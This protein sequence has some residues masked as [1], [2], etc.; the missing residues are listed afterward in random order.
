MGILLNPGNAEFKMSFNSDIYVDKSELIIQTNSILNKENRFVCISRPRRFGKSMAANMLTAYYSCGCD[1]KVFFD[2]LKIS[3]ADDYTEP[4]NKYNVIHLNMTQYVSVTGTI[5]SEIEKLSKR[6][7]FELHKENPDVEC[8]DPESLVD[9][10]ADIFAQKN[11][12]FIFIIDE[13]D[14]IFRMHKD[15]KDAQ[16]Y[17]LNF[18]RNL[19]K[20]RSY[21]ALA[22]MTGILPIKKYG[23]HSALNMFTEISIAGADNYAEF[24]GFTEEEVKKL[25]NKY[26]MPYDEIKQWYDGYN[27]DNISIYN[28]KSVVEAMLRHRIDNFWSK[29]ET[30]KALADYIQA[31]YDDLHNKVVRLIGG[32]K[33]E[34]DVTT[35]QNDMVTFNSS[36]DIL[37]LLIHLGYLTYD[38]DTK[39]CW[40]PN[41]E[42]QEEFIRSIKNDKGWSKIM[43]AIK[44]SDEL[45]QAVLD[46]NADIVAAGVE[47]CHDDNT[48]ILKFNDENSLSCV[49][50][51]AFYSARKYYMIVREMPAGKGFADLV[52]LPLPKVDKPALV[53]ELKNKQAV[54]T[55]IDQIKKKNYPDRIKEYIGNV[56]LVGITYNDDKHH[57]CVI[58]KI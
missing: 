17:Y 10:L 1:S 21:V 45:L 25:C 58:E 38:F 11:I 39:R 28:P 43:S 49:I 26:Q 42:V 8:F 50:S 3:K 47:K 24:T 5:E 27:V 2:K 9:V 52:F 41:S 36:D 37:T 34:V 31:D 13:W 7:L 51:L 44:E 54:D 56:F 35:F 33:L 15:E 57:E 30:F 48:S 16:I 6:L 22:Y 55:A 29:T 18:L 46:G 20:D 4:L 19:L 23:E 12:P 14:C 32:E 53:I 40:I